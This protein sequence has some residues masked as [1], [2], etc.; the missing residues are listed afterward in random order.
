VDF[1]H[2]VGIEEVGVHVLHNRAIAAVFVFIA[3]LALGIRANGAGYVLDRIWPPTPQWEEWTAFSPGQYLNDRNWYNRRDFYLDSHGGYTLVYSYMY[4]VQPNDSLPS[5]T[6]FTGVRYSANGQAIASFPL[7]DVQGTD[8][9]EYDEFD[10]SA[11]DGNGNLYLAVDFPSSW[12]VTSTTLR[13]LSPSGQVLW[14]RMYP[15][16]EI[17]QQ[18]I[19]WIDVAKDGK[20]CVLFDAN[21]PVPGYASA[22]QYLSS[23][24][25]RIG[26][27]TP[28]GGIH[29]GYLTFMC[30]DDGSVV[31]DTT[32]SSENPYPEFGSSRV[33]FLRTSEFGA[34]LGQLVVGDLGYQDLAI[35]AVWIDRTGTVYLLL[36]ESENSDFTDLRIARHEFSGRFLGNWGDEATI[37]YIAT[38]FRQSFRVPHGELSIQ[39]GAV[40]QAWRMQNDSR[41]N[42]Y[43]DLHMSDPGISVLKFTAQGDLIDHI[44]PGALHR[45]PS[46]RNPSIALDESNNVFLGSSKYSTLHPVPGPTALIK[47]APNGHLAANFSD[48]LG[49]D[50][51]GIE[52]LET[53][54]GGALYAGAL[55]GDF[56]RVERRNYD[57][58][59]ID[60]EMYEVSDFQG[61]S[62]CPQVDDTGELLFQDGAQFRRISPEGAVSNIDGIYIGVNDSWTKTWSGN[63]YVNYENGE[64]IRKHNRAGQLIQ[65]IA[66]PEV[67]GPWR[68]CM[69]ADNHERLFIA[70]KYHLS[71]NAANAATQ[72]WQIASDGQ[73][74]CSFLPRG[75]GP[76]RANYVNDITLDHSGNVYVTQSESSNTFQKFRRVADTRAKRAIVVAGQPGELQYG[77]WDAT[78]MCANFAYR[79]L[80]LQGFPDTAIQYLS[81]NT[82]LM[83]APGA[84]VLDTAPVQ[85]IYS[86]VDAPNTKSDLESAL[87]EWSVG[88]DEL[89]VYLVGP[90]DANGFKM[91]SSEILTPSEL[92]GWINAA[93]GGVS[94]TITVVVDSPYSGVF[95]LATAAN[96]RIAISSTS[97]DGLARFLVNGTV[98]YSYFFWEHIMSG[99]SVG[100][101]HAFANASVGPE[102]Q[103]QVPQIADPSGIAGATHI[104]NGTE[105]Y[106]DGPAIESTYVG[107]LEGAESPVIGANKVEDYQNVQR[108][109]ALIT[110]PGFGPTSPGNE[111]MAVELAQLE[112]AAKIYSATPSDWRGELNGAIPTADYTVAVYSLD[113][114]AYASAPA[115]YHGPL[116]L[117]LT[118]V[119]DVTGSTFSAGTF[120]LS[121]ARLSLGTTTEQASESVP[122]GEIMGQSLSAGSI[123]PAGSAVDLVV[124]IGTVVS[125]QIDE[126]GGTVIIDGIVLTIPEGEIPV[127]EQ[128]E[129][130][131]HAADAVI[132]DS[133]LLIAGIVDGSA[134]E[135]DGLSELGDGT[136]VLALSYPD[137]NQDGFVDETSLVEYALVILQHDPATGETI[138][139]GGD[140]DRLEN[141]VTVTIEGSSLD[142]R[143]ED[144]LIYMLGHDIRRAADVDQNGVINAVDIQVVTNS[145]LGLDTNGLVVNVDGAGGVDAIDIQYAIN[146]A[147]GLQ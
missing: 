5:I 128:H 33:T 1:R 69:K 115:I 54:F 89:I 16:G 134:Y 11:M 23:A 101:A 92:A 110:A 125:S 21:G 70:L 25:H 132:P 102:T 87:T 12:P 124:S 58:D 96:G 79:A 35:L 105:Q 6:R 73:L 77:L 139:L 49:E 50:V 75:G 100:E 44:G 113:R 28:P 3:I 86:D 22:I 117:A 27:F 48:T 7:K 76:G 81:P 144:G 61:A 111:I 80:T 20:V 121:A 104:G 120:A 118:T 38:W 53:D 42:R 84:Y 62:S 39:T 14:E 133:D 103:L 43:A 94:G 122:G 109:F 41:G 17:N 146:I 19:D 108:V 71:A 51:A 143:G 15:N 116:D 45:G 129:I 29:N 140:V 114:D 127:G 13:K 137:A 98:S 112:S 67:A 2:C 97:S 68:T 141:T 93:D 66:S 4:F 18:D 142:G 82:S 91:A 10:S 56:V 99:K 95:V 119:P 47:V 65:T 147:L 106:L 107:V 60:P 46:V 74:E 40:S 90:G 63:L 52:D 130:S 78:H 31:F 36:D 85:E 135:I 138:S 9:Y 8:G 123:V 83:L 72:I 59:T 88:A 34:N 145:A 26:G 126:D 64:T 37:E 30:L 24:G 55:R 131:I 136:F 57:G 32:S